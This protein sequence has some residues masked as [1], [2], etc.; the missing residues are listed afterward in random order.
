MKK[1]R[2]NVLNEDLELVWKEDEWFREVGNFHNELAIVKNEEGKYNW[3]DINGKLR[4]PYDWFDYI[5]GPD[6]WGIYTITSKSNGQTFTFYA[7]INGDI[8]ENYKDAILQ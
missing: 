4:S 5:K 7:D 8:H 1:I 2:V 3:I 6:G